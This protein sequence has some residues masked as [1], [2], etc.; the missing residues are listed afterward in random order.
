V[1]DAGDLISTLVMVARAFLWLVVSA[2]ASGDEA[3]LL[4]S[5]VTVKFLGGLP[6]L[7]GVGFDVEGVDDA[8]FGGRPRFRGVGVVFDG[9]FLGGRPRGRPVEEPLSEKAVEGGVP[10]ALGV[11]NGAL[12]RLVLCC[13][14][15][16]SV[17]SQLGQNHFLDPFG[18]DANGGSKQ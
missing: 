12:F 9:E 3:L 11:D 17:V 2:E 6:R 15:E 13:F 18:I 4:E 16:D 8:D 5:A 1:L 10:L 7:R 14:G